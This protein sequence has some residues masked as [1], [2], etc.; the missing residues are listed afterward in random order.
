MPKLLYPEE[1][2]SDLI[3]AAGGNRHYESVKKDAGV[4]PYMHETME[5]TINKFA[6]DKTGEQFYTVCAEY[7]QRTHVPF[8]Q[9]LLITYVLKS[10]GS[11]VI[12]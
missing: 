9:I 12:T 4:V 1:A 5:G 10:G 7:L 3:L 2:T 8:T 6:R 11:H